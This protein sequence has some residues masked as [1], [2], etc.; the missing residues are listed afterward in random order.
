[1]ASVLQSFGFSNALQQIV[2]PTTTSQIT[3]YVWGAGGGGGGN[4]AGS[5][6]GYGGGAGFAKKTFT[7]NNNDV[8]QVAVAGAGGAGG[9]SQGG[10]PG[11]SAGPSYTTS[12]LWTTLNFAGY[13]YPYI[14]VTNGAY[15]GFL[16]N[17]GVWNYTSDATYFDHSDTVYFASTGYYNITGSC[18]N[19]ATIYVDG[20]NVLDIPGF[21]TTYSNSF[22]VTAG[23]H[24]IRLYGVNTGGPASLGVS[25]TGGGSFGGG[26][27]SAAGGGGSSGGG[28]GGGGSS[29]ILLN[30]AP[31]AI[32]GGGAGAGGAGNDGGGG[33]RGNAPG[34]SGQTTAGTYAGQNGQ[35]RGG[36]GGGAGGGGGGYAGG[37]GGPTYGG[38][39]TGYAGYYGSNLG[40]VVADPSGRTPGGSN[41]PYYTGSAGYGGTNTRGGSSGYVLLDMNIGGG[42]VYHDGSWNSV[43]NTYVKDKDIWKQVKATY[44]KYGSV[45]TPVNGS[46]TPVITTVSGYW[47]T[48]PRSY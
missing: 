15:C 29:V 9:S 20:I 25:I 4:D 23:N 47:G 26:N 39:Q 36:D 19:Y 5:P 37:N 30:G 42:S 16:N 41:Q 1:M 14:R 13:G 28:G 44:I 21:Q 22:Y 11:G 40:D 31:I 48:D 8:L 32:A 45:W 7:I 38:D 3:A 18:D 17:Y 46:F 2:W 12:T 10:A 27:G 6:G 24:N 35:P 34:P 43:Q 33:G